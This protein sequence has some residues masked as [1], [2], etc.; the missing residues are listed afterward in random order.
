MRMSRR[1]AAAGLAAALFLGTAQPALARETTEPAVSGLAFYRSSVTTVEN[2]VSYE[3]REEWFRE[4][5][6]Q[7]NP[8]LASLSMTLAASA[9]HG[10]TAVVLLQELGFQAQALHYK[11]ATEENTAYVVG[12]RLLA[13]GRRLVAV[14][15]QGDGYY[16]VGWSQSFHVG[17]EGDHA[18]F[19]QAAQAVLEEIAPA[20]DGADAVWTVGYSR[21]G[22]IAN[23]VAARLAEQGGRSV[24]GY[25]F[26][27]PNTTDAPNAHGGTYAGIHNY[28]SAQDP[29][30]L[31]PPAAWGFTRYGGEK[32]LS[33][34]TPGFE[35]TLAQLN[36]YAAMSYRLAPVDRE[37]GGMTADQ[38]L[39]RRM[40]AMARALP[41]RE[42]YVKARQIPG[43]DPETTRTFSYE[44][45][46]RQTLQQAMDT[47]L[48]DT[49]LQLTSMLEMVSLGVLD[50]RDEA[51]RSTMDALRTLLQPL[52][53]DWD[54]DAWNQA[55]L[56]G[57]VPGEDEELTD[58]EDTP[59]TQDPE[60][61]LPGILGAEFLKTLIIATYQVGSEDPEEVE[62]GR[63]VIQVL[64][65]ALRMPE[66]ARE[67]ESLLQILLGMNMDFTGEELTGE[68]LR[69]MSLQRILNLYGR[70]VAQML[71]F[72]K[73]LTASHYN[74]V[75]L[76]QL[77]CAD[78]LAL[79]HGYRS[80]GREV[81]R[82]ESGSPV[83]G[84]RELTLDRALYAAPS[85]ETA[86]TV[87]VTVAASPSVVRL[88]VENMGPT[89]TVYQVRAGAEPELLQT[90]MTDGGV[91]FRVNRRQTLVKVVDNRQPLLD[92]KGN[93]WYLRGAQ[94]ASS[95]EVMV[96]ISTWIFRPENRM[97]RAMMARVLAN[98]AGADGQG[99]AA[100]FADVDPESWYGPTVAW[101]ADRGL[102]VGYP[103]GCFH[104]EK[105][106]TREQ[107]VTVLYRYLGSPAADPAI[108][109]DY[110]DAGRVS[111]FAREAMAYA[112]S[113]G[114]INGTGENRLSPRGTAT[115]AEMATLLMRLF[116]E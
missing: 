4:D 104:P 82:A 79:E 55:V 77:L 109:Q 35:R 91:T 59:E 112:V 67:L 20:L 39:A 84:R 13:D 70:P 12:T 60:I 23:L 18:G 72:G 108:L 65:I 45:I 47:G 33:A 85:L 19:A 26:S 15:P 8:G 71:R 63:A 9:R 36:E 81:V 110:A 64:A 61:E 73:T 99:G 24:Y 6:A 28:T 115:R 83:N 66:A 5:P 7:A 37:V 116:T 53:P 98:L 56:A 40:E 46:L 69:G 38:F 16:G 50:N 76:A 17:G 44:G 86:A 31:L 95:H 90:T 94:W 103:D 22:G 34:Q 96:G 80:A 14:A 30:P 32:E 42:D 114:M 48:V 43:E 2:T 29:I 74:D 11:T 25:T 106:I 88:P 54:E 1:L 89:V 62:E 27:S 100:T 111:G 49:Y 101:A 107:M 21:G 75:V 105:E 10:Q 87:V 97:T 41:T 68:Q 102:M 93:K 52:L 78:S 113:T 58:D 3:M 57:E 92:I 51:V